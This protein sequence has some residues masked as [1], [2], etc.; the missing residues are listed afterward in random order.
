MCGRGSCKRSAARSRCST[1]SRSPT[2]AAPRSA[3][4]CRKHSASCSASTSTSA[5]ARGTPNR[6]QSVGD[7]SAG[8]PGAESPAP[9][10]P[11]TPPGTDESTVEEL[12]AAA[13]QL[14]DEAQ[15]AKS[16]FDTK[17]YEQKIEQAYELLR[18]ATELATGS[19]VTI[20]DT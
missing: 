2:A 4:R 8:E 10:D 17:T 7:A 16:V 13:G 3:S 18:Q 20:V 11:G 1:R 9:D 15:E 19:E 12:L 5:T 14:F 6:I